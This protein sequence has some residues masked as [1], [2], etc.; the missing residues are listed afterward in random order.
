MRTVG[1]ELSM[2]IRQ[3]RTI[4]EIDEHGEVALGALPFRTRDV[5]ENRDVVREGDRPTECCLVLEGLV[6]RYKLVADGRRQILS[7]HFPGDLPDMQ[8]LNLEVMDHSITALTPARM[9]FISHE[10]VRQV[11]ETHPHVRRALTKYT[12]VDASIYREWIANVGRRTALERVAHI[13][14]EC[15]VRMRALGLVTGDEFELPLTQLE[16][17]D[18]T[19]LSNVHV[20]RTLQE[21]R[22]MNLISISGNVHRILD[23]PLL[24]ETADFNQ[25][26]LHLQPEYRLDR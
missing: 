12:L 2:M 24:Q 7:F 15:Y 17:G 10:A 4:A 9:A 20:N 14:C 26:Y 21:L 5:P 6:A 3:L 13:I 22:R 11:M 23:W 16:L 1:S 8:G 18:A 19:G 25:D